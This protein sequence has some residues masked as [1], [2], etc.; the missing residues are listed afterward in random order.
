MKPTS[1]AAP[2]EAG[3]RILPAARLVP[4]IRRLQ[5]QGKVVAFTNGCFD[6]LHLGH[7]RLLE[8]VKAQADCLIV[9]INSDASVRRL[10]GSSRPLVPARERA[11]LVASLKPVDYVTVFTHHTPWRIIGLLKP[12]LLAKGGDW[13]PGQIVGE[14]LV[15]SWGGRVLR[16]AFLRGHS[17]SGLMGRMRRGA[18]SGR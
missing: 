6:L 16:V 7:V 15:E 1:P 2:P 5:R 8:K 11:Y 17:T 14:A 18:K 12:D 13:K 4:L 3:S 10:K 9:G